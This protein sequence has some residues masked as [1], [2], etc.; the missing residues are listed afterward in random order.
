MVKVTIT[1]TV[2]LTSTKL[3]GSKES[4]YAHPFRDPSVSVRFSGPAL[5]V[6]E[7]EHAVNSALANLQ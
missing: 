4:I 2:H 5:E 7:V 3:T 6:T 1:R